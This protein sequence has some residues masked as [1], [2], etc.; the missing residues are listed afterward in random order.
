MA[1]DRDLM[2][3]FRLQ[4]TGLHPYELTGNDSEVY[5]AYSEAGGMLHQSPKDTH[6]IMDGA[7]IVFIGNK[8]EMLGFLNSSYN[9]N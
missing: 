2:I 7:H 3:S 9:T 5:R 6:Y 1:I 8:D 4:Q